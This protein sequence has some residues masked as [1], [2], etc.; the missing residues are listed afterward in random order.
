MP[1]PTSKFLK[2][3]RMNIEENRQNQQVTA[4]ISHYVRP[5]RES[6]Y[7]EWL[8]GISQTARQFEGHQGVTILRPKSDSL[9]EYVII[10]R[11]NN[12]KNLCQWMR[13]RSASLRE[14]APT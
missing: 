11:F 8:Q 9:G 14:I 13:S 10:L 5:G 2:I 3:S 12:Y 7:E 6:G 1:T 4:V